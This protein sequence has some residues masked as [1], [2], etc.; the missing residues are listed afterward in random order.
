MDISTLVNLASVISSLAVLVSLVYLALQVRQGAL[1]Q[2]SKMDRGRSEQVGAWLQYIAQGDT[3]P[4]ILRGHAG[5]PTLS[6]TECH[7]YLWSMYPLFLHFE[8]SYYQHRDGMLGEDQYASILGHLR[9]QSSTPGFRALWL[10]IHDR[11]P[12]EFAGFVDSVM[13]DT[14]VTAAEIGSWT[15][16]WKSATHSLDSTAAGRA[17]GTPTN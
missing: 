7:R 14:P 2:R 3:A 5:D 17:H 15:E 16:T 4:L 6:V 13:R 11:F 9:S 1:H 8:D 12:A 10:H